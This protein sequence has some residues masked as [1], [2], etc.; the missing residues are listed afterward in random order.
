LLIV[1]AWTLLAV[2]RTPSALLVNGLPANSASHWEWKFA[3]V[4]ASLVPWMLATPLILLVA[5]KLPLKGPASWRCLM[6]HLLLAIAIIVTASGA[7]VLLTRPLFDDIPGTELVWWTR[8]TTISSFYA[9]TSYVA[10]LGIGYA[11]AYL[12]RDNRRE[13][14]LVES[15][16]GALAAQLNP[17]FLFNTLNAI[18]SLGYE[19]PVRA[20]ESLSQLSEILR[21]SLSGLPAQISLE[22]EIALAR[23]YADLHIMLIPDRLTVEF[24]IEGNARS[25]A[26]PSMILQP[27]IEN[28]ITHGVGCLEQGGTVVLN[29]RVIKNCL[30]ITVINDGPVRLGEVG[31]A[32]C[33]AN[34]GLG[35]TN[36]CERLQVL[37]GDRHDFSLR[38]RPQGGGEV[39]LI[40]PFA[41]L[42]SPVPV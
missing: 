4:L 14:L 40:I 42:S 19:D 17:H 15:R 26:V 41:R 12:E 20:D 23:Q 18:S 29:A 16:L 1:A 8:Q 37:Y 22:D 10:V 39:S 7:G 3:E 5:E 34:W 11:M 33:M 36:V 13:Q 2:I 27:L 28:A 25:A 9:V 24:H 32:S 30:R 21:K 31:K 6:L 38:H 35:L